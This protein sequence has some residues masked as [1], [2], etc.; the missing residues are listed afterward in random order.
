MA[1]RKKEDR[2]FIDKNYIKN[3]FP[4]RAE[5]ETK[6]VETV[7]EG[8]WTNHAS[9]APDILSLRSARELLAVSLLDLG[10]KVIIEERVCIVIWLPAPV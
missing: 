2:A 5:V 4:A 7:D 10:Q 6:F 9:T 3:T 8:R 1:Q